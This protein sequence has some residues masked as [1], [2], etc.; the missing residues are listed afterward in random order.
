MIDLENLGIKLGHKVIVE[1]ATIEVNEGEFVGLIGP[2]G[3]GK[4]TILKTVYRMINKY[5]GDIIIDGVNIN[6][7]T[8]RDSS[9]KTAV[10][11]QHTYSPFDFKV[12]DVVM[13]G[14]APHKKSMEFDTQEDF[15]IADEC[16]RK[17]G[18]YEFAERSFS[19]LSGGEQQRI[20]LARAMAQKT[21][22]MVLDEPTNHLDVKYQLQLMDVVKDLHL[23]VLSAL[24]DLNIAAEY[25]DRLYLLK[26]GKV[27]TSGTP[28]EV[29][30]PENIMDVYGV[31]ASVRKSDCT[32]FLH[33]EYISDHAKRHM[34]PDD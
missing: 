28:E 13:M 11:P 20:V 19:T 8:I 3:S 12:R 22:C 5:T 26:N 18:M 23:T 29:L 25:C 27:Y 15:D 33:I 24:H 17:V 32:G 6:D 2:N 9:L 4:S 21:P 1:G 34:G 14:R 30:T 10:V 16:L 7:C 31:R